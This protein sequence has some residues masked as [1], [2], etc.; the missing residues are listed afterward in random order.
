MS[1]SD[2]DKITDNATDFDIENYNIQELISIIGLANE[3]PLT[4]EK[5]V[6][7][8]TTLKE[9]FN[10]KPD[11]EVKDNFLDF[12]DQIQEK[13][14]NNKKEETVEDLFEKQEANLDDFGRIT[15]PPIEYNSRA[16]RQSELYDNDIMGETRITGLKN[17]IPFQAF[18][19][20]ETNPILRNI[21]SKTI[22]I[23]SADR[24]NFIS[25]FVC[26]NGDVQEFFQVKRVD[27]A[28]NFTVNINPPIKN[29]ISIL[30]NQT[31]IPHSWYV[32]SKDYGTN[33]F[34]VKDLSENT[35]QYV[36][37]D[38]GNY[39]KTSLI[40]EINNKLSEN[41]IDINFNLITHQNKVKI[42]NT[43]ATDVSGYEILWYNPVAPTCTSGGG[44]GAKMDYNLGW[45]LGFHDSLSAKVKY[46]ND[47]V[48]S[49]STINV[50][51]ST[52]VY[53]TLDDFNP[54]KPTQEMITVSV[55]DE[56]FKMPNYYIQ[57]TMDRK[58]RNC[59]ENQAETSLITQCG[60]RFRDPNKFSNLT[61]AKRY[62]IDQIR[63]AQIGKKVDRY[64]SSNISDILTKVPLTG[65]VTPGEGQTN[66][67]NTRFG[68]N[69]MEYFGPVTL[70]KLKIRLLNDKG[71][72]LNM[73]DRDWSF[74]F[75]V[76]T[77]YQN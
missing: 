54:N 28:S 51:G 53:I 66:Y 43:R 29:V 73:N 75:R 23:N 47:T 40:T 37:I 44:K 34:T 5:I 19:Q 46:F 70:R 30:F 69:N 38:D 76:K 57:T 35:Q 77:I 33:Y 25:S 42:Q 49:D 56:N 16:P 2:E 71:L 52:Y 64:Y 12:F 4:N 10:E 17:P 7:R 61:A 32:F 26:E 20:D 21:V 9:R 59:Q 74:S 18:S 1:D 15:R 48:T 68:I 22:D 11:G 6:S 45:L 24:Q 62:T 72:E 31:T 14:L 55:D 63:Q 67:V 8:I 58:V 41:N 13:L 60:A 3:V 36:T 39:T 27:K 50:I 65:L